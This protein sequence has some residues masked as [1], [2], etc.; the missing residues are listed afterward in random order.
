MSDKS[1]AGADNMSVE[2][3]SEA[4][5]MADFILQKAH[6]GPG[7]TVE[8][9]MHRAEKMFGVP[10]AW[11]HR[12]RYRR[13]LRDMPASALLAIVSGYQAASAASERAYETERAKHEPHSRLVRLA[14]FVAGRHVQEK[15]D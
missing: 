3:V 5:G 12:L 1:S 2:Y 9:A 10:Y 14:D 13:D 4:R 11:L 15:A 7:D 8:A 6:R